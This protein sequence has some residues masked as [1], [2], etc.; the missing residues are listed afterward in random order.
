MSVY[1]LAEFDTEFKPV[2]KVK[3]EKFWEKNPNFLT[4]LNQ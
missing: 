4:A 2:L 1:T 3:I